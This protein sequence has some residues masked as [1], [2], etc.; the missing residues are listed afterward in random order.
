MLHSSEEASGEFPSLYQVEFNTFSAGFANMTEK[1]GSLHRYA[2][3]MCFSRVI[4][5]K[6]FLSHRYME[7]HE[8]LAQIHQ[9]QELTPLNQPLNGFIDCMVQANQLYGREKYPCL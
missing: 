4:L 2:L 1:I 5:G 7:H 9:K 8:E 3:C 6:R